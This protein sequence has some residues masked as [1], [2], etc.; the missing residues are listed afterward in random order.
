MSRA[1][2]ERPG[3]PRLPARH[4]EAHKGDFGRVLVIAG[5]RGLTG[6]AVLSGEAALRGGAGLV[7][8]AV[9]A[10]QQPVV[11]SRIAAPC[12]TAALPAGKD[13]G[14]AACAV[15]PALELAS[16]RDVV[17]LGPGLG[18]RPETRAF[19]SE[20]L[21]RL[22]KPCVLDADGLNAI[23]A[24]GGLPASI[25]RRCPLILTPHPGEMARLCDCSISEIQQDRKGQAT[26]LA[27]RWQAVVVLKGAGTIITDGERCEVHSSANPGLATGGT[28]DVLTG[29]IAAMVGQGLEPFEAAWLGVIFHARAGELARERYGEVS[30]TAQDVLDRLA[31]A[32]RQSA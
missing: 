9:P 29:L 30:M 4:P 17:A 16:A 8:V 2:Q 15:E 26:R 11:A 25:S 24:S 27:A 20:F 31:D 12:M 6:A 10:P 23:A 7:T 22:E 19:V 5:A 14:L 13:D 28:G 32:I 1:R 3:A 21:E 18:G